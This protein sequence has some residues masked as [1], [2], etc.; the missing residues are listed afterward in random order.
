MDQCVSIL[1]HQRDTESWA[2]AFERVIPTRKR[3]N[4][5]EEAPSTQI[6]KKQRR[7]NQHFDT[8]A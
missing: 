5:N 1:G 4:A 6:D 2:I 3:K 7:A 8:P